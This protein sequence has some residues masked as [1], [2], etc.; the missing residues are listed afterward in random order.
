MVNTKVVFKERSDKY[1]D[2]VYILKEVENDKPIRVGMSGS[3]EIRV[4]DHQMSNWREVHICYVIWT[5]QA[6]WLEKLFHLEFHPRQFNRDWFDM[7][8]DEGIQG[9]K[10]LC[11]IYDFDVYRKYAWTDKPKSGISDLRYD[12]VKPLPTYNSVRMK[13]KI[14]SIHEVL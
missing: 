8:W 3:P 7:T 2:G 14:G 1:A 4:M 5:N 13:H 9:I 6:R 10:A 12:T 11:N